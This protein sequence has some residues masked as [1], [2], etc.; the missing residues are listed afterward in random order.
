MKKVKLIPSILMLVL[1]VGVLAV[2][3]YAAKP[4]V[5]NITGSLT[6]VPPDALVEISASV[7]DTQIIEPQGVAYGKTFDIS[8]AL[9]LDQRGATNIWEVEDAVLTISITNLS[10]KELGAYFYSGTGVKDGLATA[11]D[12]LYADTLGDKIDVALSP[13]RHI[14]IADANATTDTIT[15]T[16][17]FNLK[18]LTDDAETHEFNYTLNI[19]EYVP[20][21]TDESTNV[22][23]LEFAKISSTVNGQPR[24]E[25]PGSAF[26][27]SDKL[28]MV[29]VP[30]TI[31]EL[32]CVA[33]NNS[34][35]ECLDYV[36]IQSIKLGGRPG[37]QNFDQLERV[38]CDTLN[39]HLQI[40][41]NS[42]QCVLGEE[43]DLYVGGAKLVKLTNED[44]S[45]NES[46]IIFAGCSS[47]KYVNINLSSS[48]ENAYFSRC[49]SLI[50]LTVSGVDDNLWFSGSSLKYVDIS[51]YSVGEMAFSS[52]PAVTHIKLNTEWLSGLDFS[53]F[54]P[55]NLQQLELGTNISDVE[56]IAKGAFSLLVSEKITYL[57][58]VSE[59]NAISNIS[60]FTSYVGQIECSDGIIE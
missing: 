58:T 41:N 23:T 24:T 55:V 52:C 16:I 34:N 39:K 12:I 51:G 45:G 3:I 19:E 9:K 29:C 59:F 33:F 22:N 31:I 26:V 44:I 37:S 6:I 60:R 13:Y 25:V 15:M 21:Y 4:S 18:A 46:Y 38:Y 54:S 30:S 5:N 20:N 57:G 49:N 28:R 11:D 48:V 2:G 27:G 17:G 10:N 42:N 35:I 47:L 36:G 14:G 8:D 43:T 32:D 53:E 50:S 7:G 1:C 40:S 56:D